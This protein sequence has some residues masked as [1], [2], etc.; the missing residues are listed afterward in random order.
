[1]IEEL[2]DHQPLYVGEGSA[3]YA[4]ELSALGAR[5]GPELLGVP[6]ASALIRLFRFGHSG[7]RIADPGAWT[8]AYLRAP[9]ATIPAPK[10]ARVVRE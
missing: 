5:V 6:R 3:R 4:R 7:G 2:R 10:R 8:P 9:G 1:V